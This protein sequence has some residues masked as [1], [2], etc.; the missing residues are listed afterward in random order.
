MSRW[1]STAVFV[2]H[3]CSKET[4]ENKVSLIDAL[5]PLKLRSEEADDVNH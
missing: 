2:A 4:L 5:D 3:E 1:L